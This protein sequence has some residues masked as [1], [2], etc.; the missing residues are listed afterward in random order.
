[1]LLS[2]SLSCLHFFLPPPSF[3]LL[4]SLPLS[5]VAIYRVLSFKWSQTFY[6]YALQKQH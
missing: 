2:W 6:F 4:I 3:F 1:L 5:S